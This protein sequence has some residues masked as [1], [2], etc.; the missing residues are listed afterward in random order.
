MVWQAPERQA[1]DDRYKLTEVDFPD[2]PFPLMEHCVLL[3]KRGSESHG[4]YI[5]PTS[6]DAF[7][8]RDIMG[9]CVPPL[10]YHFGLKQWEGVDAIK[11][12]WDTVLYSARKFVG[13]LVKQ[14]PNVVCMLWLR[15][16]DYLYVSP[17]GGLLIEHR[18]L[19]R[20]RQ[21]AYDSFAGYAAAQLNKMTAH[22]PYKGYMGA[23][24]KELVDRFG[25]DVKNAAHLI[26][27]LNT[28]IGY[29]ATGK[30]AV[31]RPEDERKVL[32]DI[33]Q[34]HWSLTDVKLYA[35]DRFEDLRYARDNSV[36]PESVD[37]DE[38]SRLLQGLTMEQL[39]VYS[40]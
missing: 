11:G 39:G 3:G 25:Y 26:R 10:E 19:F 21:P 8:D 2:T 28:G 37:Y 29:L 31:W 35:E 23:K 27:L 13:L 1:M 15:P 6:P 16:E 33:K 18:D 20:A 14:N 9:V 24:R 5:K 22:Q 34:G 38:A 32:I 17:A 7:D 4:T 40:S 36:L 30:L 12:C